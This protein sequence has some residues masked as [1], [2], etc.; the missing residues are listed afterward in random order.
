MEELAS[1]SL[2]KVEK[3]AEE[4]GDGIDILETQ[5][6]DLVEMYQQK[7]EELKNEIELL[8]CKVEC[9]E[10]QLRQ[11][12]EEADRNRASFTNLQVAVSVIVF[13]YGWLYGS[14]FCPA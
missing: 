14:Y 3:M 4:M 7:E 2:T 1:E 13:A 5:C 8:E 9:L 6:D 10:H 11:E 12:N